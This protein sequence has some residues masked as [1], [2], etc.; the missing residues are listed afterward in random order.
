MES[1]PAYLHNPGTLPLL[2]FPSY[3]SYTAFAVFPLFLF[4]FLRRI[5]FV[6]PSVQTLCHI[7]NSNSCVIIYLRRSSLNHLPLFFLGSCQTAPIFFSKGRSSAYIIAISLLLNHS[8]AGG[9]LYIQK[10]H[11][12]SGAPTCRSCI[13][14]EDSLGAKNPLDLCHFLLSRFLGVKQLVI[15]P[16]HLPFVLPHLVE[17]EKLHLFHTVVT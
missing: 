7:C 6:D 3:F 9:F 11:A 17:W 12:V 2:Q 4:A 14:D 5:P 15:L 16:E 1:L 10:G 13:L 8:P